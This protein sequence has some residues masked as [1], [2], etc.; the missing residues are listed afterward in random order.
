[1]A[2]LFFWVVA[3]ALKMEKLCCYETLVT[4]YE[5]TRRHKSQEHC[6]PHCR[7]NVKSH[8]N[9]TCFKKSDEKTIP[10]KGALFLFVIYLKKLS[11]AQTILQCG[12]MG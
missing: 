3:A 10:K 6:L 7:E 2:V 8:V 5:C 11:V 12:K 9:S 1:M 4:G